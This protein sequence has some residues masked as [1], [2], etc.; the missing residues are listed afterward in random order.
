MSDSMNL[1]TTLIEH[2]KCEAELARLRA[3]VEPRMQR[4]SFAY[5]NVAIDNPRVTKTDVALADAEQEIARLR[6]EL[7]EAEKHIK[8]WKAQS[9]LEESANATFRAAESTMQD[10]M[11][12]L[13]DALGLGDHA[14]DKSPH[15]VMVEEIIPKATRYREALE[16]AYKKAEV[17]YY[18]NGANERI[19]AIAKILQ[20]AL[21]GGDPKCSKS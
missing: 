7:A 15:L 17:D 4:L 21:K 6:A 18:P 14:R 10:D 5:G 13:L 1:H 16:A 11:A 9:E 2:G 3:L 12:T 19:V 8:R 20:A